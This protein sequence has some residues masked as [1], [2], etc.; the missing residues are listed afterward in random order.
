MNIDVTF[1]NR[2]KQAYDRAIAA[3]LW[4]T[5]YASTTKEEYWAEG[6]QSWFNN[7]RPPDHDHNHVDTRKELRDY[8]PELAELCEEAFGETKLVY[9]KPATRLTGHLKGFD[10]AKSPTFTWPKRLDEARRKIRKDA[11][12]RK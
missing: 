4:K 12:L 9:T 10:P 2:L 8:D 11:E 5:K 6:V 7:N 3:G 1:D